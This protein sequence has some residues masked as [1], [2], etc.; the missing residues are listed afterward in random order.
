MSYQNAWDIYFLSLISAFRHQSEWEIHPDG[1]GE[2]SGD[3]TVC[4]Y[5]TLYVYVRC[6]CPNFKVFFLSSD[7]KDDTN[8]SSAQWTE[9][10][11]SGNKN[12]CRSGWNSVF[13]YFFFSFVWL[14]LLYS[15][16]M[17][18]I[19]F[20][21]RLMLICFINFVPSLE[22]ASTFGWSLANLSN[23]GF[24]LIDSTSNS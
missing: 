3:R 8:P 21:T 13:E 23:K 14:Q 9:Q 22:I 17:D 19:P 20:W 2:R 11:H 4:G 18:V 7:K 12:D 10:R 6:K 16:N 1:K 5:V 15:F 24:Q